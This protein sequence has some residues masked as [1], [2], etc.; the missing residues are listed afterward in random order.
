MA[1]LSAARRIM[2]KVG[3]ALLVD[4]ATGALR[5]DWLASLAAD[6]G[7]LKARLVGLGRLQ[8]GF[9]TAAVG[10]SAAIVAFA[11]GWLLRDLA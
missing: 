3:S 9:R 8:S 4:A 11:V 7:A 2:V 1:T 5:A 10:G 6:V